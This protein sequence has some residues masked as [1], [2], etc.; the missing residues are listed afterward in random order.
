MSPTTSATPARSSAPSC[1]GARSYNGGR[2]QC[3]AAARRLWHLLLLGDRGCLIWWSEDCIDWKSERYDLTPRARALAPVLEEMS[4]PVAQIFLRAQRQTDP[5]G[6]YY[7]QPSIQVDWLLESTVD[8]ATW[9]RRFSSFEA[10]HNR[11]AKV[12]NGW[13]KALQDLGYSPTFVSSDQCLAGELGQ[14]RAI[15][16]PSVLALSDAELDRLQQFI[17]AGG[18]LLCEGIPGLFDPHGKLRSAEL[19]WLENRTAGFSGCTGVRSWKLDAPGPRPG[20]LSEY[21]SGRLSQNPPTDWPQWIQS[22]LALPAQD[23]I[24]PLSARVRVHRFRSGAAQLL[25]L[26]RNV[27]YHMSE[28]L[29]QAGGN[30]QLE[31][32]IELPVRLAH[33]SHIY[34][35]HTQAISATPTRLL[36]IW[37]PGAQHCTPC[38]PT[39][40]RDRSW[41][42]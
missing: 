27:D 31:R 5:I 14:Y 3:Q 25:A 9:L 34:D 42:I 18:T 23:C 32:P 19:S 1:P 26:E 6:I 13:L 30:E 28:D 15:V 35:L 37:T 33:P 36:A 20:S 11:L 4:S 12:R 17:R 21:A 10:D 38:C 2:K 24:V 22:N 41:I 29:K 16:L 8:G 40:R 39:N 7:S